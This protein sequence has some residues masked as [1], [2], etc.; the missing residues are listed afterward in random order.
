MA[1]CHVRIGRATFSKSICP[2]N[3]SC[4]PASSLVS[5]LWASIA[6]HCTHGAVAFP[7]S[8]RDGRSVRS[9]WRVGR[10]FTAQHAI[11]DA[12][13][14]LDTPALSPDRPWRPPEEA[15]AAFSSS[16]CRFCQTMCGISLSSPQWERTSSSTGSGSTPIACGRQWRLAVARRAMDPRQGSQFSRPIVRDVLPIIG[17]FP[18]VVSSQLPNRDGSATVRRNRDAVRRRI[19]SSRMETGK[20]VSSRVFRRGLVGSAFG[21]RCRQ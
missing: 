11:D 8:A 20:F 15:F 18:H 9:V 21:M 1:T 13:H 19:A 16:G 6:R 4:S 5:A 2:A 14:Y 7:L 17:D 10:F 3:A 12:R